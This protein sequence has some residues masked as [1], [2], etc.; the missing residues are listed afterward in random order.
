MLDPAFSSI[1]N[2]SEWRQ[3]WKK[4]WYTGIEKSISEIEYYISAGKLMKQMR[5]WLN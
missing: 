4:D 2:R 5:Y 3:F 1:E